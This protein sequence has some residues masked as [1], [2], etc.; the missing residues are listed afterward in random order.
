MS[1]D[2]HTYAYPLCISTNPMSLEF[3][4]ETKNK[5]IESIPDIGYVTIDLPRVDKFPRFIRLPF[6]SERMFVWSEGFLQGVT[7]QVAYYETKPFFIMYA[8]YIG[9]PW[10]Y[11]RENLTKI[12]KVKD[13]IPVN[14]HFFRIET[15]E[16]TFTSKDIYDLISEDFHKH[17]EL[18]KKLHGINGFGNILAE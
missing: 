3:L 9:L 14:I 4:S 15:I 13:Y 16:P 1:E 5:Y 8:P 17:L 2:I 12:E 11:P 7:H 18:G 6:F 10:D